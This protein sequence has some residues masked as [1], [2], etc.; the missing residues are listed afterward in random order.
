MR[1]C[2]FIYGVQPVLGAIRAKK[3]RL[4]TLY[5]FEDANVEKN[6]RYV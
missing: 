2:E 1:D 4:E 3:R 5:V 6:D